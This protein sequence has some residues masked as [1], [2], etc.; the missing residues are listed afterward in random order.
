MGFEG[1]CRCRNCYL[2]NFPDVQ[3]LLHYADSPSCPSILAR[4]LL[5]GKDFAKIGHRKIEGDEEGHGEIFFAKVM[6][7][8]RTKPNLVN[9]KMTPRSVALEPYIQKL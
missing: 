5:V 6:D 1:Q 3:G 2:V 9:P 8:G 4:G 7:D